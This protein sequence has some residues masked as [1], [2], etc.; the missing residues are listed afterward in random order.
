M[1]VNRRMLI[2][3]IE[4]LIAGQISRE[5]IGW[6]AYDLLLGE[7]LNYEPGFERLLEDTLRS[8]HYFHEDEP[9]MQQFYPDTSEILYYLECLKGR[10]FYLRSKVVHWKV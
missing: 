10:E 2:E 8:L 5:D 6:W 3:Q 1:D 4:K 9:M 7:K